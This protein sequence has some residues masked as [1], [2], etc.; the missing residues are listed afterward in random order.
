MLHPESED[1]RASKLE[2]TMSAVYV[3]EQTQAEKRLACAR[4]WWLC[5]FA[6]PMG[7]V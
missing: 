7:R 2:R 1:F 5:P 6:M 3:N 4:G